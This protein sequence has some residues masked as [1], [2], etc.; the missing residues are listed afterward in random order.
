[1]NLERE[2]EEEVSIRQREEAIV[3][4]DHSPER[5]IVKEIIVTSRTIKDVGTNLQ[6]IARKRT[7][8]KRNSRRLVKSVIGIGVLIGRSVT[9]K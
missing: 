1:V 7:N 2:K 6:E 4:R 9:R 5:G 3:S 8:R